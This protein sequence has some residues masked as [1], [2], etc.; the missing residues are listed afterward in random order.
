MPRR[1]SG[2]PRAPR[3]ALEQIGEA[4]RSC[5]KRRCPASA[6]RRRSRRPCTAPADGSG[7]C[8]SP[9]APR[10]SPRTAR[11]VGVGRPVRLV[12]Q[13]V[14]L[15]DR[16]VAGLQHLDV[17]PARRSRAARP[18]RSA[19]G[20]GT[21]PRARSRTTP[22]RARRSASPAIAR[23][24]AWLCRFGMPGRTTP[25]RRSASA[26]PAPA[27]TAAGRRAHR[28]RAGRRRRSP[29]ATARPRPNSTVIA[30]LHAPNARRYGRGG[31]GQPA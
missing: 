15:A 17:E 22:R 18:G 21:S 31:R 1:R 5:T 20:S 14:E 6:A 4:S 23:W 12:M 8:R 16:G 9:A 24:K 11:R 10:G 29:P 30:A 13:V 27:S 19:R 7:R 2:S 28:P 26:G 25:D 3:E